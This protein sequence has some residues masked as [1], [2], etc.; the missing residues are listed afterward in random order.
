MCI[1][2]SNNCIFDLEDVVLLS[3]EL[4]GKRTSNSGVQ[5]VKCKR[6]G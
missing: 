1:D 3:D 5:E 4:E 6:D 2:K